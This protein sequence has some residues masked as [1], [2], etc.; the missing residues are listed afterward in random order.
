MQRMAENYMVQSEVYLYL[1]EQI[2]C[3]LTIYSGRLLLLAFLTQIKS[4]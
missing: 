4:S 2:H 1:S 3:K